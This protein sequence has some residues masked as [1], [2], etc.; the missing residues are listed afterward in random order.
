MMGVQVRSG[1][2]SVVTTPAAPGVHNPPSGEGHTSP[3]QWPAGQRRGVGRYLA[4]R[5]FILHNF[6]R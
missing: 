1:G 5:T 3:A 4:L 2:A 6:D